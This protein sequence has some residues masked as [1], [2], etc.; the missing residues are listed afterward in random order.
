MYVN[1]ETLGAESGMK[2]LYFLFAAG[3]Q[4]VPEYACCRAHYTLPAELLFS[5]SAGKLYMSSATSML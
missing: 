4:N 3:L 1:V 5:R 2:L